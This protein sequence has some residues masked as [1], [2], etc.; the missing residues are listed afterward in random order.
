MAHHPTLV[1]I[2]E[3]LPHEEVSKPRALQVARSIAETG[4][5][6]RP[7]IVE[8]RT[9]TIIDG[10]HRYTALKMLG[11]RYAPVVTASYGVEIERIDPPRRILR[12]LAHSPEEA[13][14]KAV[15][16]IESSREPGPS[17]AML[18]LD[19]LEVIVRG[20]QESL[21]RI[22]GTP[23]LQAGSG[24]PYTIK[25]LIRPLEPRHV[26]KASLAGEVYPIK[27]TIHRTPL[28]KL[29]YPVKLST[30]I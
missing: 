15:E 1:R 25:V 5:V 30:L 29:Y 13:L 2:E 27:T 18:N 26:V 14:I 16:I 4:A 24:R 20:S 21:H 12:I 17:R 9:L 22:L 10:H 23:V 8:K 6:L 19:G 3:L 28:K 11:A 7:I